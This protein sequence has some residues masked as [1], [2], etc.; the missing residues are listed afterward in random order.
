MAGLQL[1][2]A[3]CPKS[4]NLRQRLDALSAQILANR[5]R[6]VEDLHTLDVGVKTPLRPALG[7]AD[8]VTDLR[9]FAAV[10]ALCHVLALPQFALIIRSNRAGCYHSHWR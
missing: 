7:M 3:G 9:N 4:V 6:A 2:G 1:V 5:F 10:F 8:V